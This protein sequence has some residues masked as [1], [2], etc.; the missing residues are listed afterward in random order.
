MRTLVNSLRLI[1]VIAVVVAIVAQWLVSSKTDVY[2]PW[3]F[4]GYFT[5]QSNVIIAVALAVT[6]VASARRKRGDLR[7]SLLRG[8]GTVYIA[9]TGIVYNTLL[10]NVDVSASVQWSNDVLHKVIP[11]YAVL[12]WLLFSDRSKLLLRH[13]WWFLVYPAVW[14]IVI[15]IRGA[16]DGWVPYP[17]LDPAQGYGVVAIYCV[18]VG[19]SIGLLGVLVVGMSRLRLV[20]V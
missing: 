20:K 11:A 7:V 13:V 6:L 12:D 5:I 10:T 4:F 16:T 3:N 1:A 9:T 15:L 14:T 8:A 18:G 17:F 19:V 2:N